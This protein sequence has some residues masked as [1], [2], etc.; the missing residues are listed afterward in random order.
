MAIAAWV[1]IS[2]RRLDI[3]S[4]STPPS[5]PNSRIG[6]NCSAAVMPT[7]TPLPVS[8]TTSHISA[9]I[10]IQLPLIEIT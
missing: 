2:S 3:R 5:A 8:F 10:C 4:A 1:I 6:R 7:E 9:T